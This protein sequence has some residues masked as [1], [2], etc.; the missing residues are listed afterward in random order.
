MVDQWDD[1]SVG[2]LGN[3]MGASLVETK[4]DM[5]VYSW[6]DRKDKYLVA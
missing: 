4:V 6:V 3:T 1:D 5:M 2:V